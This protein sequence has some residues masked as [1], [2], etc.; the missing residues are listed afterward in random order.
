MATGR[1][2]QLTKQVGE[3]LVAAELSRR[4]LLT[5]TFA[6]NVPAY[7]IV[8]TGSR[9]QTAL[10]QVKAIAGPSWQFDIRTFTDV[11]YTAGAQTIGQPTTSPAGTSSVCSFDSTRTERTAST[12]S[13][14]RNSSAC[15]ST[16]T[17]TTWS[18]TAA[19]AHGE[20]IPSTRPCGSRTSSRS[21]ATGCSSTRS[22]RSRR[23]IAIGVDRSVWLDARGEDGSGPLVG[24][25]QRAWV[26]GPVRR[27]VPASTASRGRGSRSASR[28]SGSR[29]GECRSRRRGRARRSR[30]CRAARWG[31]STG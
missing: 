7:D 13:A 19:G 30:S 24:P 9:G 12:C 23:L 27:P 18:A 2:V 25:V 28:S 8:A 22:R 5:A 20:P 14:G 6:G 16:A 15:S 31:G 21:W 26:H 1:Q 4:G 11:R 3:Y 10:V 29:A 17:G